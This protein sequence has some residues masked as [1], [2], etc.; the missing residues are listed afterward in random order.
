MDFKH[1]VFEG[2]G[3]KGTAYANVP[4][5]LQKYGVLDKIT[6]VCGS[7]AGSILATLIALKYDPKVISKIVREMN[8]RQFEERK[9]LTQTLFC[10]LF[11]PGFNTGKAFER[12]IQDI[13]MVK[14]GCRTATF[15]D[16]YKLTGI[17]LVVTAT[18]YDSKISEYFSYKNAPTMPVWKAV[19]MSM[20]IPGYFIPVIHCE[21]TY[22]DGGIFSNFP[23]WAFDD[24]DTYEL[25]DASSSRQTLGFRLKSTAISK[26]IDPPGRSIVPPLVPLLYNI[27][28]MLLEHAYSMSLRGEYLGRI[29]D[30]NVRDTNPIDFGM[31]REK[32]DILVKAGEEAATAFFEKKAKSKTPSLARPTLVR[33]RSWRT[34]SDESAPAP[35]RPT[36]SLESVSNPTLVISK[37]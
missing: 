2:G 17:E 8:F 26:H 37:I 1:L 27:V 34:L 31:S 33:R 16:L 20:S 21:S 13:I 10:F 35:L 36:R 23:M 5:V 11:K 28:M 32:I 25:G 14:A 29:I 15:S 24:P 7:S 22:I 18:S 19:R 4:L 3:M 6:K 12:W 9:F 30:I